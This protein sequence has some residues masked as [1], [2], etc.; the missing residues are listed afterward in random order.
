MGRD[1]ELTSEKPRRILQKAHQLRLPFR[2]KAVF[3]LVQQIQGTGAH[4][5]LEVVQGALPVGLGADVVGDPLPHIPGG[6]AAPGCQP[7]LELLVVLHGVEL[8]GGVLVVP[9][10][11][12]QVLPAAV[13]PV[14]EVPH[15]EHIV[16][17]I[18]A[19]DDAAPVRQMP[20]GGGSAQLHIVV[21]QG[22]VIEAALPGQGQLLGDDVQDGALA[23][24]VA[25]VKDGHGIK[26]DPIPL[27]FGEMLE[28]IDTVVGILGIFVPEIVPFLVGI[29][30]PEFIQV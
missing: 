20:Q 12:K 1:H 4:L 7:L 22:A 23:G 21:K 24:A 18:V 29:R 17:Y 28:R 14:V 15:P 13:H 2:G 16:E 30:Q 3:R 10:L 19:G 6:G 9:V 27:F 8:E 11:R 5:H 26:H 25:A